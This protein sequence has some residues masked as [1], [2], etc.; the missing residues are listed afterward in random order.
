MIQL[1]LKNH[2]KHNNFKLYPPK[3]YTTQHK[4]MDK[5]ESKRMG[6]HEIEDILNVE[7]L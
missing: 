3:Q 2:A 7:L 1:I 4:N 6:L 5:G